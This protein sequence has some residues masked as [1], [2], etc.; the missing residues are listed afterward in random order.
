[1]QALG[2]VWRD[3][4]SISPDCEEHSA[5]KSA[6]E[7]FGAKRTLQNWQEKH[8]SGGFVVGRDLPSRV[9]AGVLRNLAIYEPV[10]SGADF[11]VRVA[12]TALVR[13]YGCDVTG[14]LLSQLYEPRAFEGQLGAM[15]KAANGA[16][17][18]C[19]VR[20]MRA[21]RL[22]LQYES[23]QLPVRSPDLAQNWVMGGF[24][25]PDWAR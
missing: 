10:E 14:L 22:E 25:Y 7:H 16:P 1:M 19:D 21:G 18:F 24:F 15:T 23:L 3:V 11:R 17:M 6:P 9:L 12:G 13:R 20:V 2:L 5:T 8:Q 4:D